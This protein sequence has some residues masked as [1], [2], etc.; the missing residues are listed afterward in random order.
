MHYVVV[1]FVSKQVQNLKVDMTRQTH[2]CS[3]RFTYVLNPTYFAY[4][5]NLWMSH[6]RCKITVQYHICTCPQTTTNH[7]SFDLLSTTLQFLTFVFQLQVWLSISN[8]RPPGQRTL[9][10]RLIALWFSPELSH[11]FFICNFLSQSIVKKCAR[12]NKKVDGKVEEKD[13]GNH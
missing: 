7:H 8:A 3:L 12:R 9:A 10:R 11:L 4:F 6:A 1:G 2:M 5:V 13:L